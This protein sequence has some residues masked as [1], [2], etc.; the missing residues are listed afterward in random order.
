MGIEYI[1]PC[2]IFNCKKSACAKILTEWKTVFTWV[3]F[4]ADSFLRVLTFKI[5]FQSIFT[6]K[7][8]FVEICISTNM[9]VYVI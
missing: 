4:C 9:H 8:N 6:V 5:K 3:N 7:K 1:L 2:G